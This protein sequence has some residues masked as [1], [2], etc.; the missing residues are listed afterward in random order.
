MFLFFFLKFQC[1]FK[2]ASS[3]IKESLIEQDLAWR[4]ATLSRRTS[5]LS[6]RRWWPWAKETFQWSNWP[7]FAYTEPCGCKTS[8]EQQEICLTYYKEVITMKALIYPNLIKLFQV[9]RGEKPCTWWWACLR[10]KFIVQRLRAV[11]FRGEGG[12]KDVCPHSASSALLLWLSHCP[13]RRKGQRH[14]DCLQQNTNLCDFAL[15][16]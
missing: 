1:K 15:A 2:F 14:F 16:A 12:S 5:P 9:S 6:R 7:P 4:P 10:G 13:Q 11:V 3:H 8:Q